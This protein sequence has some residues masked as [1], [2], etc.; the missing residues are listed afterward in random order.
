MDIN[1]GDEEGFYNQNQQ[2]DFEDGQ[3]APGTM[4]NIEGV[5]AQVLKQFEDEDG[6]EGLIVQTAEGPALINI[7]TGVIN[8]LEDEQLYNILEELGAT[9]VIQ[10]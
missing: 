9:D 1:E 7:E 8:M 2:E 6:Q 5:E 10:A 3:Y 4:I